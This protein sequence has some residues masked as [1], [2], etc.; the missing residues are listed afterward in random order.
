MFKKDYDVDY[1]VS[2][3]NKD[4]PHAAR[5]RII[6]A[7]LTPT[8]QPLQTLFEGLRNQKIR[9]SDGLSQYNAWWGYR[10][11]LWDDELCLGTLFEPTPEESSQE[12]KLQ[13]TYEPSDG[14]PV[15]K[16]CGPYNPRCH[17]RND[18]QQQNYGYGSQSGPTPR[19]RS[20]E[21]SNHIHRTSQSQSAEY[22]YVPC[23]EPHVVSL[24]QNPPGPFEAHCPPYDY[25]DGSRLRATQFPQNQFQ[26]DREEQAV[27][28]L[29]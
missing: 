8:S 28:Q 3:K 27:N 16:Q 25:G 20:E 6:R 14:S 24:P 21:D 15:Q 2:S 19:D 18:T 12:P 10:G 26:N 23:N 11:K 5:R 1:E 7:F 4:A 22:I 29:Q 13:E 17:E 9:V